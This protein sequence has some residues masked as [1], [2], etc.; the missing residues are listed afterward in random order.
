MPFAP[1]FAFSFVVHAL[2]GWRL[3]PDLAQYAS[4]T[5]LA[6]GAWLVLSTALMPMGLVA[7]R[8]ANK[9][10][11]HVLTW[12]GLL[13]MGVFSSLF[14]L[15]VLRE[16]L[17]LLARVFLQMDPEALHLNVLREWSAALIPLLSI[18]PRWPPQTA[19]LMA[20]QTAPGR[21]VRL[22]GVDVD[23]WGRFWG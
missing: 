3:L 22:W 23:T 2:V 16:V 4:M 21:T 8:F 7:Q 13:C 9:Q 1:L 15:M 14:A 6:L 20:T 12:I 11:G 5:G 18:A 19:P 10:V 17:L